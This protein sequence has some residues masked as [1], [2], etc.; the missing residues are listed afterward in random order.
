MTKQQDQ[1]NLPIHAPAVAVACGVANRTPARGFSRLPAAV[2]LCTLLLAAVASAQPATT[3]P[4]LNDPQGHPLAIP[5]QGQI[6]LLVFLRADQT[7]SAKAIDLLTKRLKTRKDLQ[8]IGIVSGDDAAAGAV[9]LAASWPW[10]LIADTSYAASGKFEVHVWPTTVIIDKA[11]GVA[12]GAQLAHLPG[13]PASYETDVDAYLDFAAGKIDR[14]GLEKRLTTL[15]AIADTA[16]QKASRHVEVAQR[17]A[18]KGMNDDARAELAKAIDLKPADPLIQLAIARIDLQIGDPKAAQTLLAKLTD[19]ALPRG[20]L[21]LL[22]GWTALQLGNWDQARQTLSA[23]VQLNPDPADTLYL[24]GL[25]AQ[26]DNDP[27]KA[28][29]YFR[30]AFEHTPT[31]KTMNVK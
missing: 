28:A 27:A 19:P 12:R 2:L 11:D 30:K 1:N 7:Q 23:S 21:S 16:D 24:L 18:E 29:D 17:L 31:G 6:T 20:E 4:A 9:K 5:A 26:H 22:A 15:D 25:I 14:A 8:I 3:A 13:M 10:P